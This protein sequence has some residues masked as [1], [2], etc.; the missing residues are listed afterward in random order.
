L[1]DVNISSGLQVTG[2]GTF[3]SDLQVIGK[4]TVNGDL[5]VDGKGTIT[6]DLQVD[7]GGTISLDLQVNG[8]G[9]FD[10]NLEVFGNGT[11]YNDLQVNG[12]GTYNLD[13]QVNGKGSFGNSLG[14]GTTSP[15]EKLHVNGKIKVETMT[16]GPIADSMMVS[17]DPT[18]KTLRLTH[19]DSISGGGGGSFV[20]ARA[21]ALNNSTQLATD[22]W[23]TIRFDGETFDTHNAFN[24]MTNTFTA[25][26]DGYYQVNAGFAIDP[27]TDE[28]IY[29]RIVANGVVQTMT[30][31]SNDHID[32]TWDLYVDISDIVYLSA[33][34][35]ITIEGKTR[36][37]FTFSTLL[38]T[39]HTYVSIAKIGE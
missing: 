11:F 28:T 26:S 32:I 4:A 39:E 3:N 25:P 33:Q 35:T 6:N 1:G 5:Q 13:L 37:R 31:S 24:N 10:N 20:S 27:N 14:I 22:Q 9:T 18:D 16:A 19:K 34:Q 7:G 30:G 23:Y 38:G 29:I 12:N 17:W 8:D 15:D 36:N 2:N 21:Y